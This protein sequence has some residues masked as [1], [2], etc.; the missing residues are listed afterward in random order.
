MVSNASEDLPEPD[1]PVKTIRRSRG[2]S[3]SIFRRLWVRA[4]RMTMAEVGIGTGYLGGGS[5]GQKEGIY[6]KRL[7]ARDWKTGP[8]ASLRRNRGS[9]TLRAPAGRQSAITR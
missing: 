1:S 3:R 4:P 2:S 7:A 5:P 8:D 6:G 9:Q